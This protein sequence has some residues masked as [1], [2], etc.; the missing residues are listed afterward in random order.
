MTLIA[1]DLAAHACELALDRE[2]L[3]Q[4]SVARGRELEQ[5][6]LELL[7]ARQPRLGIDELVR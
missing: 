7:I 4:V 6:R 1:L 2:D 5:P 3:I